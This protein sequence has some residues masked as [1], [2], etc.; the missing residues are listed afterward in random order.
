[1]ILPC[2]L[3][4]MPRSRFLLIRNGAV[5]LTWIML[6]HSSSLMRIASWSF[7]IPALLTRISIAPVISSAFFVSLSIA[8]L[9][10]RFAAIA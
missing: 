5:R 4:I 9:S 3:F 10:F 1:M 6:C 8:S 7:V 2:R